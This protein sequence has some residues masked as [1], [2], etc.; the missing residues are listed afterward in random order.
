MVTSERCSAEDAAKNGGNIIVAGKGLL[1]TELTSCS[2][3]TTLA[4][5]VSNGE[6]LAL[7]A[8]LR[9]AGELNASFFSRRMPGTTRVMPGLTP[10]TRMCACVRIHGH[11]TAPT[12]VRLL[13]S[14]RRA[15]R[16]K[17]AGRSSQR[18]RCYHGQH[19][20]QTVD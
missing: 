18:S 17:L 12:Q 7:L 15:Q 2:Q 3:N 6:G 16:K 20:T 4:T 8:Y 1:P 10:C 11:M 13:Q 5:I 19:S 9:L 14:T